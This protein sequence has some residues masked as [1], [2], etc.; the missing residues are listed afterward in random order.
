MAWGWVVGTAS[1]QSRCWGVHP[2]GS[3]VPCHPHSPATASVGKA[4]GWRGVLRAA[5]P[6]QGCAASDASLLQGFVLI[7]LPLWIFNLLWKDKEHCSGRGLEMH[8][9][10]TKVTAVASVTPREQAVR[11]AGRAS[12]GA[13]PHSSASLSCSSVRLCFVSRRR[14][15]LC[16]RIFPQAGRAGLTP[17]QLR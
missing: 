6:S 9:E 4:P 13:L 1:A 11:I 14:A 16:R 2:S 3:P 8:L 5:A 15:G 12:Q 17:G 10:R 7:Y